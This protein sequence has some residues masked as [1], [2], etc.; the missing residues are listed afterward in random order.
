[1]DSAVGFGPIDRGSNPRRPVILAEVLFME[2]VLKI[3]KEKQQESE[4]IDIIV[5]SKHHLCREFYLPIVPIIQ[6][7]PLSLRV[8]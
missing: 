4:I 6:C 1:M 3:I 7:C 2:E 5:L 8:F